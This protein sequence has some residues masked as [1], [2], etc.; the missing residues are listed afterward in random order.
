MKVEFKGIVR[1]NFSMY[2]KEAESEGWS[3]ELPASYRF[4]GTSIHEVLNGL[5]I[6]EWIFIL[7][8]NGKRIKNPF[9]YI[10]NKGLDIADFMREE[11]AA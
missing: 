11:V 6:E 1:G 2:Q 5:C 7:K 10:K 9:E 4:A 8:V 3:N